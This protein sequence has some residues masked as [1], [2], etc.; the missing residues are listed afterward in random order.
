MRWLANQVAMACE[1]S[2]DDEFARKELRKAYGH[3][4]RAVMNEKFNW[5]ALKID[6]LKALGCKSWDEPDENGETILLLPL[7]L[8]KVMPEGQVLHGIGG[9]TA[10]VGKDEIH[11]DVRFGCIPYGLKRKV[12]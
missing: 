1:Y 11:N 7:Y 2:W 10:V 8:L 6:E 4:Q 3:F 12:S 5:D 9:D